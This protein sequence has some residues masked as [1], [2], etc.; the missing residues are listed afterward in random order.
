MFGDGYV[1]REKT[2]RERGEGKQ[3]GGK[4]RG[5]SESMISY[6]SMRHYSFEKKNESR[7]YGTVQHIGKRS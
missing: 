5:Q 2:R 7:W 3:E 6:L 1:K 4:R